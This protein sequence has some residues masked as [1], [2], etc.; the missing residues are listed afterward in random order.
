MDVKSVIEKRRAYRSLDPID[1]SDD[2]IKDLLEVARIAPSCMNK[3]PWRLVFVRD[4]MI[5]S[6]LFDCLSSGN[7]WAKKASM[8][9]GVV[10]KPDYD[11]VIGERMYYLLDVGMATAFILLRATELGLVAH[12]I[13]GYNEEKAKVALNIPQEM[14]LITL[15]I[16][17]KHSKEINPELS[18]S[19]KLGEKNRPPRV[20]LKEIGFMDRFD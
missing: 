3:Q 10:S 7:N 19:M 14:R 1:I 13:A 5:L 6:R 18:E 4:K 11:C 2:T 15:V 17:G 16:I 9:I 20:P 8:I 12:P